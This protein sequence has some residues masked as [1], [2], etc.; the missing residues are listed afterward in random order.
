[1]KT[2]MMILILLAVVAVGCGGQFTP[3]PAI[4]A[5]RAVGGEFLEGR[6]YRV[7]MLSS[8]QG[9]P[10]WIRVHVNGESVRVFYSIGRD[11]GDVSLSVVTEFTQG[12]YT[13]RGDR[14]HIDLDGQFVSFWVE[15][16]PDPGT[17]K[18]SW[19]FTHVR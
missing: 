4:E 16:E 2:T 3:D 13:A 10:G 1:M 17:V 18:T 5:F 12:I 7:R 6:A 9:T 15:I 19:S 14:G 8:E 11:R